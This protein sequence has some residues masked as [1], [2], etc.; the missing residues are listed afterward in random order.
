MWNK[1]T[2]IIILTTAAALIIC[3]AAS[4]EF[5]D[6]RGHW[7]YEYVSELSD[8]NVVS[9]MEDGMFYP[10]SPVTTEQFVTMVIRSCTGDIAPSGDIW[11]SG[12]MDY[13]QEKGIID[14][15]DILNRNNAAQR[16]TAARIVHEALIA[17][18]GEN[19]ETDWRG[20]ERLADLYDCHTCVSHIVQVY[21]KGIMTG[22][23]E[24]LFD[25]YGILTRAEAAAV[26]V[27]MTDK[28]KRVI[29]ANKEKNTVNSIT[30]AEAF[31]ILVKN[32][33]AIMIDVRNTNEYEKGHIDRSVNIPLDDIV[34]NPYAV[35]ENITAPVILYCSKGY[36]R[37]IAAKTLADA[38]YSNVY[39]MPGTEQYVY[40]LINEE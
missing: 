20:A 35:N 29:S 25:N 23:T 24:T 27:R 4:A 31:A 1:F 34:K 7:A 38:G 36:R 9:G 18:Y 26:I 37:D 5:E 32:D 16:R 22:R 28:R 6:M 12:Y 14:D 15:Y 11:S 13:A 30:P 40:D 19:D 17:L 21:A 33:D 8:K 3:T 2:R 10:E 39:V